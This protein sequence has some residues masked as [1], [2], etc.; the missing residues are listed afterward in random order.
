MA[1]VAVIGPDGQQVV[2]RKIEVRPS[3][4]AFS[5]QIPE[6]GGVATGEYTLRVRLRSPVEGELGL[7]D[8]TR[9]SIKDNA[10]LGE[11][12]L[13]RRGPTTG[14]QYL[15]TADPRFQRSDRLRLELATTASQPVTARVLD[16]NGSAMP[17]QPQVSERP[18]SSMQF[19]WI[20]VDVALAPFAAGDYAIETAQGDTRQVTAFR[21]VP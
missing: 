10:A 14:P 12:V 9:V 4:G 16:R 21:V 20:V 13:W 7:S 11:A 18:D 5:I 1:D 2:S 15:R 6:S 3:E 17:V 19:K 8:T